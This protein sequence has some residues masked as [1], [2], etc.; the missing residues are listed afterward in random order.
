MTKVKTHKAIRKG[1]KVIA[2]AGNFK[3]QKGEVI[4]RLG[5]KLV[6][7]G[8]NLRKKHVKKSE[9]HP[10][11]GIIE[12]EKGIHISNLKVL[13]TEDNPVKL[14]AQKSEEGHKEWV[15]KQDD[16][17]VVHRVVKKTKSKKS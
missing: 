1:D 7:Q 12:L 3:G 17:H 15:Y 4:A 13:N 16:K 9:A 14:K 5:D 6:V 2:I 10:H 11:G 8:L